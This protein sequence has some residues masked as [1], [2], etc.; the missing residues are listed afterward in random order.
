MTDTGADRCPNCGERIMEHRTIEGL[1]KGATIWVC[2]TEDRAA[3][4]QRVEPGTV[5]LAG[6]PYRDESRSPY[7]EYPD[8]AAHRFVAADDTFVDSSWRPPLELP[9]EP[10]WGI[11]VTPADTNDADGPTADVGRW[12]QTGG[13]LTR[14]HR[15][16]TTRYDTI[17]VAG[18]AD[19]I[20]LTPEQVARIEV[21]R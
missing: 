21:A 20:P 2:G 4:W 16:M 5:I 18:L 19:F 1:R 14:T 13:I 17:T 3:K 6:Q 15:D 8:G 12:Q 9:T 10:T 7:F 11:A